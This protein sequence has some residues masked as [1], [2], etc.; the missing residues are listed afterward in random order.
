METLGHATQVPTK[1]RQKFAAA[2]IPGTLDNKTEF[3][4]MEFIDGM[5][6][7]HKEPHR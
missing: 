4:V 6:K 2:Q 3:A 7:E 5:S 1:L